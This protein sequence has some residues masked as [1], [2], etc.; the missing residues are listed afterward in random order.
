MPIFKDFYSIFTNQNNTLSMQITFH[1]AAQTVTGSKHLITLDNGKQL[2][3]DCG[4][5]QGM[6]KETRGMNENLGFD[7]TKVNYVILSHAHIDHSGLLPKLVKDGFN[8]KIYCTPPTTDIV[9]ALLEDSA[10][11]QEMDIKFVNKKRAK[12]GLAPVAAL[13]AEADVMRTLDL[14]ETVEY[15]ATKKIDDN[16]SFH[17]TDAGHILGSASVH[18]TITENGENKQLTFSGD[19][20]RYGDAILQSPAT[21]PQADYIILEST[22]GNSLH[23]DYAGTEEAL[24]EHITNTCITKKGCLVIPAFSLGRTQELLYALNSLELKGKLPAVDYYV[25]SP[26]SIKLTEIIKKYPQ[27][28]NSYVQQVLKEDKDPFDF[29]GLRFINS[30]MES[31]ALNGN[32]KPCVII[33]ASGMAEAGRVKHHIANKISDAKNTILLVG[34]CEPNGLGGRLKN[35]ETKVRIFTEMY[36]VIAEVQSIRSMS[37]HGDY[38]DLLHFLKCQDASKVSRLFLVH[39][40]PEVQQDFKKILADNGFKTVINPAMHE[41]FLLT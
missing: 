8:G 27:Y 15:G 14:L 17:Y 29:K 36:D 9:K 12:Q 41:N 10:H 11:I 2:L 35:G 16:F 34:Y 24:L 6:G 3:L 26:L 21:F 5:F 30:K 28:Y 40:E 4:L 31:M 22:Y 1:G 18:I 39:G 23:A 32:K 38:E 20:G 19:V 7:A 13:Y 37:A 25:D 33:S